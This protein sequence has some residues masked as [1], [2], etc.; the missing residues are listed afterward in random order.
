MKSQTSRAK[1]YEY[2]AVNEQQQGPFIDL[3]YGEVCRE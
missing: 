2:G 1:E 3:Y